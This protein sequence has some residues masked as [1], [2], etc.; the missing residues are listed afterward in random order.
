MYYKSMNIPKNIIKNAV[1]NAVLTSAYV[2]ALVSI[3]FY[4]PKAIQNSDGNNMILIP[5]SMLILF[6][7]SAGLT[8][9][10]VF[11]RPILWYLDGRKKD[12]LH[13]LAWTLGILLVIILSAFLVIYI[14][15]V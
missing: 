15:L 14:K 11:G 12:A 8:S 13:L 10:L 5:I 9:S 7:F 1:I 2:G 4:A 6:I 3:V